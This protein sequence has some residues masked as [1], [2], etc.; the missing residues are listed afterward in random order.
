[1]FF[2]YLPVLETLNLSASYYTS[3][4]LGIQVMYGIRSVKEVVFCTYNTWG[5]HKGVNVLGTYF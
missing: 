5:G 2:G 1:M 4:V 3:D